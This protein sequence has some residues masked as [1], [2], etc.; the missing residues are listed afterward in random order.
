MNSSIEKLQKFFKLEAE[1]GYDNRA[2]FGGLERMLDSWSAEARAEGIPEDIIQAVTARL[3]DYHRLSPESR[4]ETLLGLWNRIKRDLNIQVESPNKTQSG[5]TSGTSPR[6]AEKPKDEQEEKQE[7]NR[8]KPDISPK[9]ETRQTYPEGPEAALDAPVTVIQGIGIKYAQSLHKLGIDTLGDLLYHF[10]RRYDDY[11]KLKPINKLKYGETATLIGVVKSIRSR[12]LNNDKLKLV[13]AIINDGT[14]AIRA[15]W[16]NQPWVTRFIKENQPIVV[17]GK[18]DQYLGRLVLN[19]PEFEPLDQKNLHTNR[20]VPVYPLTAGIRQKRLRTVMDKVVNYWAPRVRDYLPE[21][22]KK[23]ENLLDLPFALQQ[24]HFPDSQDLLAAARE[25]LAFDEIFL[26]QLGVLKLK[27]EWTNRTAQPFQHDEHW[28]SKRIQQ[29]PFQLTTA[30][31]NALNEIFADLGSG[32]PMNRLLQGDVGSGKTIVAILASALIASADAQVAIMAPT[33]ILAEQHYKNFKQHLTKVD[34]LFQENEI[35]ILTSATP[36]AEKERILTDLKS[37]EI[38]IIVGTHALIE[39][40]VTFKNL[41]L[42]IIDEQHR[43]GVNQRALLREKGSN[44]HLLV[45]TATPIP[46][47]LALTLYGDLDISVIDELPRGRMTTKTHL[48]SPRQREFAYRLIRRE[49]E[50]GN[51]AFI[52]YPLIEASDDNAFMSAVQEYERLQQEIFPSFKLG[53]LHGQLNPADKEEVM[54]KFRDKAFDILVSTTVVEV[55]VDIPDATVIVIE[56]ANRF[57]LSQLHQLRGRVGRSGKQSYCILI[58]QHEDD[59]ENER[60]KVMVETTDGFMLAEKDLEQR[61]PGEFLGTRQSGFLELK[62]ASITDIQLIR[63][64]RK[65]AMTFFEV[66]PSLE[67]LEHRPLRQALERFWE[68]HQP[69]LS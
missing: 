19:N 57:G 65:Q 34:P 5:T 8:V 37:G 25:R 58:P 45:M 33:S 38:R 9:R 52:V 1:R 30:Q 31:S 3:R 54:R 41:Q 44:P 40:N 27:W 39:P 18:I 68:T 50:A 20:I 11:S 7:Q 4:K 67:S 13:E 6:K 49:I 69:D 29:L 28:L 24:I 56:G 36:Q 55:G 10:P 15:N 12:S 46:R 14:G 2:V 47:S 23:E 32:K 42:V 63:R 26:L 17:A 66:D 53:L 59:I 61:G 22:I 48:I 62:M 43:F 16:F 64:A 35:N 21:Q 51:Q 60:L